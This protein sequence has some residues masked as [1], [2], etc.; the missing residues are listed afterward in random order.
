MILGPLDV[1]A[2]PRCARAVLRGAVVP[3]VAG[4][5]AAPCFEGGTET[6]L[7]DHVLLDGVPFV[8]LPLVGFATIRPLAG[9]EDARPP[10]PLPRKDPPLTDDM[11][12]TVEGW[13]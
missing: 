4:P 8:R 6:S 9:G 5:A 12:V 1:C 13:Q 7:L 10:W 3:R 11:V 2:E